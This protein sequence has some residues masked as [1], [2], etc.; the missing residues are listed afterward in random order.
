M[1]EPTII[2]VRAADVR[3]YLHGVWCQLGERKLAIEVCHKRWGENGQVILGLDT[4]HVIG[5]GADEPIE[6][7][8][9]SPSRCGGS[10]RET[11]DT[12]EAQFQQNR[13]LV[14]S[15]TSGAP[16]EAT[17]TTPAGGTQT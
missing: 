5:V 9:L 14:E 10:F 8:E 17:C 16:R 11:I 4:H 13:P 6:V 2:T 3:P 1:S 15:C 7:V 12:K